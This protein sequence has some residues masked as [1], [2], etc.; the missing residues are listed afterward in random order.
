[1]QQKMCSLKMMCWIKSTLIPATHRLNASL[2]VDLREGGS[3][4]FRNNHTDSPCK[5]IIYP[6]Q[7]SGEGYVMFSVE[8]V[9]SGGVPV[10]GPDA[11]SPT[12][13][14][15]HVETCSTWTSL[16]RDP[17]P[18]DMFKL[19]HY[20]ARTVEKMGEIFSCFKV[21]LLKIYIRWPQS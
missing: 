5:L 1:M 3:S 10:Q 2:E 19:I 17:L 9:C 12:Q 21:F 18:P 13:A 14:P 4:S 8:S 16:Y 7:R 15:R 20:A 11:I 6:R